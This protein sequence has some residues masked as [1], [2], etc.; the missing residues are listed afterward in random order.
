MG[1]GA[2]DVILVLVSTSGLILNAYVLLVA[3]GLN[4]QTQQQQTANTVLLLVHLGVVESAVCL[5]ILLF[6]SGGWP[7]AGPWCTLYGFIFNAL[8]PV[9]LWT[10]TGLNCDRYYAISAP[11]H[12]TAVVSR[13]RVILGLITS[14]IFPLLLCL[15]PLFDIAPSYKYNYD[16]GCCVPEFTNSWGTT[17]IIYATIYVLLGLMLP[18]FLVTLCN[19]RV[20]GIARYHRH[21]IASAIYEVTLS[22]QVTITH[23]RNP[24]YVPTI[25]APSAGG[26]PRFH[27]AASTVMQLVVPLYL[28]YFPYCGLILWE[29]WSGKSVQNGPNT[30][31]WIASLAS[32][33]LALSPLINGILYGVKSR[34]LRRSFQN[35]RRK[36]VTKSELQQE[37][38][39]RTPSA[40]GSRRAS[41]SGPVSLFPFPPTQRRLSEA[42]LYL[43]THSRG[44]GFDSENTR[45]FSKSRMQFASCNTLQVPTPES[46]DAATKPV[47]TSASA[48]NLIDPA[49][50]QDTASVTQYDTYPNSSKRSPRILITRTY[51]TES[52]EGGSPLL[53]RN[54]PPPNSSPTSNERSRWRN[55]SAGS[56]SSTGS[57]DLSVWTTKISPKGDIVNFKSSVDNWPVGRRFT[58]VKTLEE[59]PTMFAGT[60]RSNNSESSD[61]TDTTAT[62]TTSTLPSRTTV[63]TAEKTSPGDT[64]EESKEGDSESES[65]WSSGDENGK[66]NECNGEKIIHDGKRNGGEIVKD[67][68]CGEPRKYKRKRR[69]RGEILKGEGEREG[70]MQLR[71]L[72]TPSS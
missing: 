33:L 36:K 28:L 53:K 54:R 26:P 51:S 46:G 31:M 56:D 68:H 20:L 64:R 32:L 9:A 4:K 18:V 59:G 3:L 58:R 25:T 7:L 49:Y 22:A 52:P 48:A 11:L 24:F 67:I 43:G 65:T 16:F 37:I 57:S 23:Q 55:T 6:S 70:A 19:L 2:F 38:Q 27:S 40:A 21:R 42:L 41:G 5:A 10:V 34:T 71:P 13:K 62:T 63:P 15:P 72:L 39:A 8:H 69:E 50:R 12:Y 30:H 44:Q 45:C 29:A 47:R 60:R 66:L 14:W 35:Y 17:G 1:L 61:T